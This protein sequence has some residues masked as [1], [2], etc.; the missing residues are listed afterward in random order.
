MLKRQNLSDFM[1][2][3]RDLPRVL[4]VAAVVVACKAETAKPDY[5]WDI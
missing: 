1:L 2:K 4:A 5:N 3:G